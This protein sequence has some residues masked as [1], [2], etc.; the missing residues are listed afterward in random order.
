MAKNA[1]KMNKSNILLKNVT[2]HNIRV[3][4]SFKLA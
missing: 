1:G 4:F 3:D 2:F